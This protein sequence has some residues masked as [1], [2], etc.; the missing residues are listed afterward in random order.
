M[1]K[2][3]A[4]STGY[5]PLGGLPRNSV[6]RLTDRPDMTSAVDRGRKASIPNKKKHFPAQ[7]FTIQ[8]QNNVLQSPAESL[9]CCNNTAMVLQWYCSTASRN[10]NNHRT[11]LK[12][13]AEDLPCCNPIATRQRRH[14]RVAMVLQHCV[15]KMNNKWCLL[16]H[17]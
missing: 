6:D 15:T 17:L 1:A 12:S 16:Q 11:M 9:P 13:L 3:C 2:K 5:L 4:L 10:Q 14:C 7:V 8:S